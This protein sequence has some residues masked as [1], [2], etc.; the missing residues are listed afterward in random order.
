MDS[1]KLKKENEQLK[2]SLY[3]QQLK[4]VELQREI[5]DLKD[6]L[7]LVEDDNIML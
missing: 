6:Q 4:E 5:E 2:E 3:H 7:Q 1:D